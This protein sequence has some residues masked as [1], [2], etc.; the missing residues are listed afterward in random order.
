MPESLI[1]VMCTTHKLK[2]CYWWMTGN[3]VLE[4]MIGTSLGFIQCHK[5]S[6]VQSLYVSKQR[7]LVICE[8][9]M[10]KYDFFV[11]NHSN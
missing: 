9:I 2:N 10:N 7:I 1:N 11:M 4:L 3:Y 5:F 6:G 8:E